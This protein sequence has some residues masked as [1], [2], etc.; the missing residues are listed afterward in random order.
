MYSQAT[1]LPAGLNQEK[2]NLSQLPI[3]NDLSTTPE[4]HTAFQSAN[5]N[6]SN[7][8]FK[9]GLSKVQSQYLNSLRTDEESTHHAGTS[10]A[11]FP[12]SPPTRQRFWSIKGFKVIPG[13][14]SMPRKDQKKDE[15][16]A[17][18][19]CSLVTNPK[20]P[21]DAALPNMGTRGPSNVMQISHHPLQQIN[22]IQIE[23]QRIPKNRNRI[24]TKRSDQ[25]TSTP[26][27]EEKSKNPSNEHLGCADIAVILSLIGFVTIVIL[28]WLFGNKSKQILTFWK[29]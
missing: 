5:M 9:P 26:S 15:G 6:S 2:L 22:N 21:H 3:R 25:P 8:K 24:R 11:R 7:R 1:P 13:L 10:P 14:R 4:M 19:L 23:I 20:V 17:S 29:K 27:V 12:I 16:Y 18:W 28:I